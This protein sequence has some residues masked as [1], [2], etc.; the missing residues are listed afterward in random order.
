MDLM[1]ALAVVDSVAERA[2]ETQER[3]PQLREA[4]AFLQ[5]LGIERDSLVWFWRSFDSDNPDG[6]W[7][8]AN[9]ARNRINFL[10]NERRRAL[11]D[12]MRHGGHE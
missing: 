6:R 4:M 12:Q 10:V 9:A 7:Q 3:G 8:N 1:Q 11:K 2:V 5:G